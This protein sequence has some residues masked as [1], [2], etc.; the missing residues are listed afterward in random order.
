MDNRQKSTDLSKNEHDVVF[1]TKTGLTT[2]QEKA[3]YLLTGGATITET[4]NILNIA[5]NTIYNWQ[6]QPLFVAYCNRLNL[7]SKRYLNNSMFALCNDA[8]ETIKKGLK[9]K[10]ESTR[11]KSAFYI[12]DSI[13][14]L[15]I[16]GRT[17]PKGVIIDELEKE[18]TRFVVSLDEID[19]E[20]KRRGLE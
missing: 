7:D 1:D 11:L 5:R 2:L 12:V 6:E 20:M 18:R 8:I 13:S 9:S 10:N 4:A 19:K 3:A 17:T 16:I 14:R 15:N